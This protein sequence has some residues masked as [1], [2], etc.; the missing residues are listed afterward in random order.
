VEFQNKEGLPDLKKRLSGRAGGD[1]LSG[2][3]V[4]KYAFVVVCVCL[5]AFCKI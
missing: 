1:P 2:L 4:L 5:S 3:R